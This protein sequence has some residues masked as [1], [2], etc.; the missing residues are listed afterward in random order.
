MCRVNL[1]N[2]SR[3]NDSQMT[4]DFVLDMPGAVHLE[5]GQYLLLVS[6]RREVL[7]QVHFA[8]VNSVLSRPSDLAYVILNFLTIQ[9]SSS[10]K[11]FIQ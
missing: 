3:Y 10:K 2:D 11:V 1:V 4:S 6:I 8:S 5:N 9:G 7:S